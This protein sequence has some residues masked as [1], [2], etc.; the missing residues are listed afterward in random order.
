MFS[1]E[2]GRNPET[3]RTAQP[4][5]GPPQDTLEAIRVVP[6]NSLEARAM[7]VARTLTGN[8]VWML[9]HILLVLAFRPALP[10]YTDKKSLKTFVV[11]PGEQ[12]GEQQGSRGPEAASGA[13][14]YQ[15]YQAGAEKLTQRLSR[16]TNEKIRSAAR[17][18]TPPPPELNLYR[19][20]SAAQLNELISMGAERPAQ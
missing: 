3:R 1:R 13:L 5:R 9:A 2:P 14:V 11:Y 8:D 16:P 12:Q 20:A 10:S 15:Q 6:Y 17:P 7:D 19:Q 4:R 18:S